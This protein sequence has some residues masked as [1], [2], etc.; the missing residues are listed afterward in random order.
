MELT[1][2]C[3]G[4]SS[5]GRTNIWKF[6]CICGYTN[7]P[8]STRLRYQSVTCEKCQRVWHCDWNAPSVTHKE[9]K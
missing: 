2:T 5:D 1:P 3:I 6:T 7:K 8:S 9:P 4:S